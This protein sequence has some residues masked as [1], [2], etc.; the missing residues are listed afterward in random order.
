MSELPH[1]RSDATS[2]KYQKVT[3]GL[4]VAGIV[5]MFFFA[6]TAGVGGT[7]FSF[8]KGDGGVT[9]V[10]I[11]CFTLA[12]AAS[13]LYHIVHHRQEKTREA[14]LE[15]DRANWKPTERDMRGF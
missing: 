8:F 15:K 1:S 7:L 2:E 14:V 4:L 13:V 10:L 12:V 6:V 9:A 11:S 3:K 5:V